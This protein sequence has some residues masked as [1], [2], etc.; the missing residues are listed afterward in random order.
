MVSNANEMHPLINSLLQVICVRV[1]SFDF[2]AFNFLTH[3]QYHVYQ[4]NNNYKNNFFLF[5]FSFWLKWGLMR[6]RKNTQ[7][8]KI[9]RICCS[10]CITCLLP[11]SFSGDTSEFSFSD[12]F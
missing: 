7:A 10:L 5:L 2:M 6:S 3:C 1:Y 4:L 11:S 12:L 8:S 9:D